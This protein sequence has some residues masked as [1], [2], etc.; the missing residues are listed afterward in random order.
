MFFV[1]HG[2][3]RFVYVLFQFHLQFEPMKRSVLKQR[4]D[5]NFNSV[6]TFKMTNV[7][8]QDWVNFRIPANP[9]SRSSSLQGSENSLHKC[10]IPFGASVSS[11]TKYCSISSVFKPALE[12]SLDNFWSSDS[13]SPVAVHRSEC[14]RRLRSRHLQTFANTGDCAAWVNRNPDVDE[15]GGTNALLFTA[16]DKQTRGTHNNSSDVGQ[17]TRETR[18]KPA[19]TPRGRPMLRDALSPS[20]RSLRSQRFVVASG[21]PNAAAIFLLPNPRVAMRSMAKRSPVD[22]SM[23]L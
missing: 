12:H 17:I 18:H 21:T 2:F 6:T 16:M 8:V 14:L 11:V 7:N 22:R 23:L 9:A 1:F 20:E 4:S 13:R 10:T 15:R 19:S 3:C 5:L